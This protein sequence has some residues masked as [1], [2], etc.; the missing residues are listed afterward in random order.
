MCA[1]EYAYLCVP[2][3]TIICYPTLWVYTVVMFSE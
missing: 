2:F 1:P 3:W